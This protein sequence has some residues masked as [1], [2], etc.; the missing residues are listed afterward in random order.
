MFA[1]RFLVELAEQVSALRV[2]VRQL[3]TLVTQ[4]I[5]QKSTETE[6]IMGKIDDVKNA[7]AEQNTV[8][9]SVVV[10][11]GQLHDQL[12]AAVASG[13]PAAVDAV[14]ADIKANTEK[15]A[16]AVAANTTA[17]DEVESDQHR[18]GM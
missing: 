5:N 3:T 2:E 7:V 10:L 11:L 15:L 18:A 1:R 12:A 13:D 16:A 14:V 9:E 6:E 4:A 8:I 17:S